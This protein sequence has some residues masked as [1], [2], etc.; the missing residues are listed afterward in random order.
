M[1]VFEAI[2]ILDR[3][4]RFAP[5]V[6]DADG[7]EIR[8]KETVFD[9]NTG[10]ELIVTGF[11]DGRVWCEHRMTDADALPVHG[12]WSPSDLTHQRPVA[13]SWERLE[14]DAA[15]LDEMPCDYSAK[16]L[17]RRCRALAERERGE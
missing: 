9:K 10:E 2:R 8:V 12:M 7:V 15:D 1:K 13:D 17:V 3:K 5:K 11:E 16:D 4:G 14:E 6:L